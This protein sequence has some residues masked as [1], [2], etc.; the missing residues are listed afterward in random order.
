[1]HLDPVGSDWHIEGE[2]VDTMLC[3]VI[4]ELDDGAVRVRPAKNVCPRCL[5]AAGDL[6][7]VPHG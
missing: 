5:K 2:D 3:G 4:I 6:E 1:V 7:V